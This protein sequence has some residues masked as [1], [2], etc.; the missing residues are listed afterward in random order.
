VIHKRGSNCCSANT[1]IDAVEII[2][3]RAVSGQVIHPSR[4]YSTSSTISGS[5]TTT[6][7]WPIGLPGSITSTLS[8]PS[9]SSSS[10]SAQAPVLPKRKAWSKLKSAGIEGYQLLETSRQ[11]ISGE[12]GLKVDLRGTPS[13]LAS[14]RSTLNSWTPRSKLMGD[15]RMWG[16]HNLGSEKRDRP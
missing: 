4:T 9:L 6:K 1:L 14:V 15:R 2:K 3:R 12:K 8:V 10:A 7:S 16:L 11:V 5:T 13:T